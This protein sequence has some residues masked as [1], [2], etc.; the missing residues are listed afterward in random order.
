MRL[1]VVV[2]G[3][4]VTLCVWIEPRPGHA[5]EWT[6]A[7]SSLFQDPLNW[8]PAGVPT[9]G[10]V[11]LFNSASAAHTVTFSADA[12]LSALTVRSDVVHFKFGE[13]VD[14]STIYRYM[15]LTGASPNVQIADD[16]GS[17]GNVQLSYGGVIAVGDILVAP[18]NG[19]AGHL[20][21]GDPGA[22][23]DARGI[24]QTPGSV[25]VGGT[26]AAPGGA[27]TLSMLLGNA[28]I[29]G[30]LKL[31]GGGVLNLD[32]A[33]IRA[34]DFQN[35]GNVSWTSGSIFV[36]N[37]QE[38]GPART[39]GD[40]GGLGT[41]GELSVSDGQRLEFLSGA[42]ILPTGQLTLNPGAAFITDTLTN[43][44]AVEFTGGVLA[45]RAPQVI[46][47]GQLLGGTPGLGSN[48]ELT[49]S[50][51]QT[52]AVGPATI[53]SS[54]RLVLNGGEFICQSLAVQ[55]GGQL[56]FATG[57]LGIAFFD[58]TAAGPF[59]SVYAIHPAQTL[60]VESVR[61]DL[62]SAFE[63]RGGTLHFA[64]WAQA[65][66]IGLS[67]VGL[68]EGIF[69]YDE[70]ESASV[71]VGSQFGQIPPHSFGTTLQ[72]SGN[73][74]VQTKASPLFV[75]E[76]GRIELNSGN[77]QTYIL[78]QRGVFEGPGT[79]TT[80]AVDN[81]AMTSPGRSGVLAVDSQIRFYNEGSIQFQIAG[82]TPQVDFAVITMDNEFLNLG[83]IYVQFVDGY[84]PPV[85]A[86]FGLIYF[87]GP[88][89]GHFDAGDLIVGGL[90]DNLFLAPLIGPGMLGVT[91]VPEAS[92]GALA[93]LVAG[94]MWVRR[95]TAKSSAGN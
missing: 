13:S 86:T 90:P 46:G 79:L 45:I 72:L 59:G 39:W 91:V 25:Y 29:R 17:V 60:R 54:G 84:I 1:S 33:T 70:V 61:A 49:V 41:N 16:P 56:A 6:G 15:I 30:T 35:S 21:V 31:W 81:Y 94:G 74:S 12:S 48:G 9:T 87:E 34:A 53:S 65:N 10:T 2:L 93:G 85:G 67:R 24:L 23:F 38:I 73:L 58:L 20:M 3:V 42:T 88:L 5:A 40:S 80:Y 28:D 51:G 75:T 52:L 47:H 95:R 57:T 78:Y 83:K 77:L 14:F 4:A 69:I 19:S 66:G 8:D 71:M 76:D 22:G 55:P 32:R 68:S 7:S 64:V 44:G 50:L 27:A 11:A 37:P 63:L 62:T 89:N 26:A 36:S 43:A 18:A 82:S 92:S